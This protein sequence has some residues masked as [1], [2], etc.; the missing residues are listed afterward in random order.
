MLAVSFFAL[1][2]SSLLW[3]IYALMHI[4]DNIGINGLQAA[5]LTD[6]S[7]Y[8]AFI[9]L[10]VFAVWVVFGIISHF[11]HSRRFSK[12]MQNLTIQMKKSQDYS[13]LI[14]RIMLENEQQLRDGFI[15]QQFDLFI[16]DMNELISEIIQRSSLASAEQIDRL[17]SKVR[18]G[19]K[20]SFGKVIIEV[21]QNQPTFQ[22]RIFEKGQHD[23]VLAGTIME[24]C[25]RYQSIVELF[26]KHDKEKVFLNI[27]ET[28]VLG[29][30]FSIFAPIS[31]E[32]K[33]KREAALSF[34]GLKADTHFEERR[35]VSAPQAQRKTEVPAFRTQPAAP[36]EPELRI[37]EDYNQEEKKEFSKGGSKF[38]F[39]KKIPL[40][41]KKKNEIEE[42]YVD[43]R[44]APVEKDP[45]SM[46]LERS[47]GFDDTRQQDNGPAFEIKAPEAKTE[48]EKEL[49]I[50]SPDEESASRNF[51]GEDRGIE[52]PA[53]VL[54][55]D[56]DVPALSNT[57]RTLESLKKE[58]ENMRSPQISH[59]GTE[60]KKKEK[61]DDEAEQAFSYPFQG[62]VDEENYNK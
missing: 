37:D 16:S 2:F 51:F 52:I 56:D 43:Y 32:L 15:L 30:V 21:N 20:W 3:I 26:E 46:A 54:S 45:F 44:T 34:S 19:G 36:R 53:P 42:E 50:S 9:L 28:G 57:H 1:I 6:I 48:P 31:D 27:I 22:I 24:F 18:N 23:T 55:R 39:A 25:A 59:P 12:S 8:T 10:P 41:G 29:K 5:G 4:A 38:D 7:I 47:F 62:W 61:N 49:R 40:F 58:W 14:A 17:W 33:R 11:M 60:E 35:P 13:D